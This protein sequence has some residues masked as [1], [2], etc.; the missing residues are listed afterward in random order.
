MTQ[1][2]ACVACHAVGP[3]RRGPGFREVA[4]RHGSRADALDYLSGK[5]RAGG[6]GVWGAVPMPPQA[7][8]DAEAR[9]IAQWLADGAGR[10]PTR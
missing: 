8:A 4:S 7:L 9:T 6:T 1:K 3:A 5:I 10:A 2:Y